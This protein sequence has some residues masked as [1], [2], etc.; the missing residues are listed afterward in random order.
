[1]ANVSSILQIGISISN[2]GVTCVT[3]RVWQKVDFV[4]LDFPHLMKTVEMIVNAYWY[5]IAYSLLQI[6]T[7]VHVFRGRNKEK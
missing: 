4:V 1:M 6:V 7:F 5:N 2:G 3:W